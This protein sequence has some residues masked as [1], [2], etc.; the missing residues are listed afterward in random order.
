MGFDSKS[1]DRRWRAIYGGVMKQLGTMIRAEGLKLVQAGDTELQ[2]LTSL[3]ERGAEWLP[4][5][6]QLLRSAMTAS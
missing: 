3:E 1:E 2:A 6:R 5:A 4:L